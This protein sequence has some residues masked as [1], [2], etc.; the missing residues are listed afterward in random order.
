[1]AGEQDAP[2]NI[3]LIF[4]L[5]RKGRVDIG[6]LLTNLATRQQLHSELPELAARAGMAKPLALLLVKIADFSLWQ[7]RFTPLMADKVLEIAAEVIKE[8]AAEAALIARWNNATFGLLLQDTPLWAAE[9]KGEDIRRALIAAKLPAVLSHEGL[10]LNC[11]YGCSTLPPHS[12]WRL[13][14]AA[15]QDLKKAEGGIFALSGFANGLADLPA[16]RQAL[17]KLAHTFLA[18]GSEYLR[19]HSLLTASIAAELIRRLGY[20]EVMVTDITS[21]AALADM[22]MAEAAGSALDK[23]GTLTRGEWQRVKNHPSL[24]ATLAANLGFSDHVARMIYLHHERYDGLG[25]PEGLKG[26]DLPLSVAI[27][28]AAGIYAALL[29]PRPYRPARKSFAAKAELSALSGRALAPQIVQHLLTLDDSR[30][31][32]R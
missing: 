32:S 8:T 11:H 9:E 21:A 29:L 3:Y 20:D 1:M 27:L 18:H 2:A 7:G 30:V 26:E 17:L 16:E 24:A 13:S 15:E 22:A 25:Y 5:I 12:L 28:S 6:D 4:P 14:P 31:L 23:P 10:T 19:R